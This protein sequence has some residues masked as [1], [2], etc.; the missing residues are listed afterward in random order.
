MGC[1]VLHAEHH[2]AY[3]CCHRGVEAGNVEP[4]DAAGLC[5]A[6]CVVEQTID[7]AEFFDRLGDQRAHLVLDRDVGLKED[8][9]GTELF[10]KRLAF[11]RAASGDDDLRAFRD[12]YL[13]G[14]QS[15]AAGRTGDDRDLAA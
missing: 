3:Q 9:A 6:A 10:G 11:R 2:A 13:R 7:A 12:E 1:G 5:R 14:A 4:F 8:A 15:D